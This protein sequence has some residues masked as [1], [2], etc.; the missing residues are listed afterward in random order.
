MPRHVVAK[1]VAPRARHIVRRSR[2]VSAIDRALRSGA[3]WVAAPGGYGKTVA[4]T[5]YLQK[6]GAPHIWYRVDDGDQDVASFFHY[7]ALSVSA[8][9]ARGMLPVFGPEYADQLLPFARRFFRAYLAKLRPGTLIVFD[10]VHNADVPQFRR[11]LGILLDE[12]PPDVRCACVSRVLPQDDLIELRVKGR[13]A[14]IDESVLRF[15]DREARALLKM[16]LGAAAGGI[17]LAPACGWA[18]GLVLLAEHAGAAAARRSIP[19]ASAPAAFAAL[20]GQLI[21]TLPPAERGLLMKLSLL[22]E[23]KPDVART[24]GGDAAAHD[25]LQALQRRQLLVTR[26]DSSDPVFH[27]H[28]LLRD[29]LRDRLRRELPAPD[30]AA[31]MERTAR[32]LDGG[33]DVDGAA[34]LALQSRSWPLARQLL[35]AH[36][37]A[38]L[39]QGRRATLI[40]RCAALPPEQLDGW[41]C[42]WLGVANA[43]DD[44]VAASWFGRAWT[45]FADQNDL[46]G[47][48]LTA[49]HAVL[50][51]ADSWRTHEGLA[52][53]TGRAIELIDREVP[54]LAPD[55]QLL[56]WTGILRAVDFAA[57]YRSDVPAVDRLTSRL[58]ER[59]ARP[60][61]GDTATRRL[62]ASEALIEHAGTTGRRELFELAVDSVAADLRAPNAS[63]WA[64]GLWLV[65]FGAISARYF[66]Y[67]RRGFPYATA[68]DA[69]R[70]AIDIGQRESLRGVEF[71]ALYHL[72][73]Q[74]KSRNAFTEF[75]ALIRRLAEIAD[76]RYTTQVA[77]VADC[78]AALH[79][80]RRDFA[81]AHA[82]CDRFMAAIEAANEP[83]LERW[84]HFIT[85]FQVLLA[86]GNADLAADFLTDLLPLYRGA[87]RQR[88]ETCVL[89][90]RACKAKWTQDASYLQRLRDSLTELRAANWPAILLN[91]PDLLAELCADALDLDIE[92]ELC[93]SLIARRALAPPDRRPRRWPW[94]LRVHVLGGFSLDRDGTRVDL[95]P[96]PP[97]R[98]L[99]IVRVLAVARDHTCSSQQIYDWL[100]PDADGDQAKSACEQALHRLRRLLGTH[101]VIVQREG[102]LRLAP[103]KVWIDLDDWET[104][105]AGALSKDPPAAE[106]DMER[107]VAEFPGP[108]HATEPMAP[109]SMAAA[110]RVRK[111]YIEVVMRLGHR[112]EERGEIQK[113]A[114]VHLRALDVYPTSERCWEGLLRARLTTGDA[115]GALDEYHRCER[116]LASVG[117][118]PSASIRALVVPLAPGIAVQDTGRT[119]SADSRTHPV[120]R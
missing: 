8:V 98:S 15:S 65:A 30:L 58:G 51:K 103:D 66:A 67:T 26:G 80:I 104:R 18:A 27:L 108:L 9:R 64:R 116:M 6:V 47:L 34:D 113:A 28:D 114:D 63:A 89:M 42:Y 61:P 20:A 75:A 120:R 7:M 70:A 78:E 5:D 101:D 62:F 117:R 107:A 90:A 99:D 21:D 87:L 37:A 93:R 52:T 112:L 16:R 119:M 57:N 40:D 13:L 86:E 25:V 36:A 73:L 74:M 35:S 53:W 77:V 44:A 96:K 92:P 85:K 111:S 88:T 68:E 31:L 48:C 91:V 71:G 41:L 49:A 83:P 23:V 109:W 32:L 12:L 97:S 29:Y 105:L 102:R 110:E 24:L 56:A 60:Q 82:A 106:V 10:D 76:S 95:G 72:Q 43:P 22:P 14:L 1:L 50:S 94:P 3:C 2:V 17:S 33:G 100:W 38:L 84:P 115:A 46:R 4:I 45:Q 19:D 79:T 118:T 59:L 81:E 55:E 69:L 11:I 54:D 39:A